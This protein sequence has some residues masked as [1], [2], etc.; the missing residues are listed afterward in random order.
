MHYKLCLMG[1]LIDHSKSPWIHD[2]FAKQLKL[3]VSYIK[4]KPD[5][6]KF[7]IAVEEFRKDK[8]YGFNVTLPFKQEAFKLMTEVSPRAAI[9]KSVN[10]VLFRPERAL[11]GDNTDGIGLVNDITQN[12]NYPLSKK[13][14]LIIGAGG[15]VRGVLHPLL[16][17]FPAKIIIVNRTFAHAQQLVTEFK[18][19]D[20]VVASH[21]DDLKNVKVDV[22][23]DGTG[24]NSPLPVPE[25]LSLSENSLCYDLKY[26]DNPTSFMKW[27]K[28][29]ASNIIVDGLGMLVAQAAEAF[30]LWTGQRPNTQSVIK[31]AKETFYNPSA[32][33]KTVEC[34]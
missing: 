6:D 23:L 14:I 22:V 32:A 33:H 15:A 29:K 10:T 25:S 8:G 13:T 11:Y 1:S 19:Y 20:N 9:A 27:A 7:L 34:K 4:V 31:L 21:F 30:S 17:Q 5:V 24:F 16:S 3:D 2:Q 26:S 12:L 18:S 28:T